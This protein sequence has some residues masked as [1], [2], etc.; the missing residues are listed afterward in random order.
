MPSIRFVTATS[1]SLASKLLCAIQSDLSSMPITTDDG[2]VVGTLQR[3]RIYS[4]GPNW[5]AIGRDVK[6]RAHGAFASQC[7]SRFALALDADLKQW[8]FRTYRLEGETAALIAAATHEVSADRARHMLA[9]LRRSYGEGYGTSCT[10]A[11]GRNL[12][13][14]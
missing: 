4:D 12:R 9:E 6:A 8:T 3:K 14:P 11:Q 2:K 5:Q 13:M 10:D 1:R 7:L